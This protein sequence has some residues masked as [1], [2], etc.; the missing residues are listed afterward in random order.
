VRSYLRYLVDEEAGKISCLV[1][2][3][4]ADAA[5]TVHRVAQGLVAKEI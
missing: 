5:N 1:D 2:A 4:D 3:P